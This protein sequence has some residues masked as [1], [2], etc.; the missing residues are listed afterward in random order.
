MGLC[1]KAFIWLG[2]FSWIGKS[3][4]FERSIGK[5]EALR[6]VINEGSMV[7]FLWGGK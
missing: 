5:L 7:F 2:E 1:F 6:R 4:R 3:Y